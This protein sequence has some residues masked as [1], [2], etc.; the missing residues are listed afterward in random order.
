MIANAEATARRW[1]REAVFM[2]AIAAGMILNVAVSPAAAA[3]AGASSAGGRGATSAASL[4][5]LA[6]FDGRATSSGTTTTLLFSKSHFTAAFSGKVRGGRLH[7]DERFQFDDGKPLQQWDLVRASDGSYRGSV[8]TELGDGTMAPPV[9]VEGHSFA[10]GVVLSYDGY[11]PG[12]GHSILGFR[13]EMA[14]CAPDMV[15]NRVTISKFG[16]P[17]AVSDVIFERGKR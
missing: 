17:V 11:A 6:F 8:T 15:A 16:I 2:L 4:S 1:C 7:L 5:L 13:H 3:N 12:G 9:P 10:G 14:W